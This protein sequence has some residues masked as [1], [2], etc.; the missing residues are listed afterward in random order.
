MTECTPRQLSFGNIGRRDVVASFDAGFLSSEG[1]VLLLGE[2][3]K[4]IGMF[5]RLAA[6]FTDRRDPDL[7]EHSVRSLV[8]Q[9]VLGLALGYEDLNDHD[10]LRRDP[11]LAAVVGEPDILGMRRGGANAGCALAGKSTL[12]RLELST[13]QEDRYKK[14]EAVDGRLDALL[15]ALFVESFG[16]RPKTLILD[17]DSTDDPLHGQQE[18]RHFS[19]YYDNYCRAT[20]SVGSS[21]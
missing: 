11:L 14:I 9:R 19:R 1:G 3:E 15:L 10:V 21:C 13:H 4:R 8:A 5:D 17:V 12:N 6:C 7:I 2:T 16:K 18:G 20:C